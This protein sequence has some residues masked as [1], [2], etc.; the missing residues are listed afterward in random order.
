MNASIHLFV[1]QL[2]NASI[3]VTSYDKSNLFKINQERKLKS[4]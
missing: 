4:N 1:E 2:N 3:R